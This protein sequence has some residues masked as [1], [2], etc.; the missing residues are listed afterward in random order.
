MFEPEAAFEDYV[1]NNP[2]EEIDNHLVW[3]SGI[4]RRWFHKRSPEEVWFKD[5]QLHRVHGPAVVGPDGTPQYWIENRQI[6][7]DVPIDEN[8]KQALI[9]ANPENILIVHN[10]SQEMLAQALKSRPDLAGILERRL[11]KHLLREFDEE[12]ALAK[13]DL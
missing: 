1:R 5:N 13:T 10:P 9:D 8:I 11:N 3:T 2:P 12:L 7:E 6:H 4:F